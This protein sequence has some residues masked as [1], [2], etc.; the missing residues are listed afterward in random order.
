M[1]CPI[2]WDELDEVKP[3]GITIATMPERFAAL[4]DLLAARAAAAPGRLDQLLAWFALDVEAGIP[5]APWPPHYPKQLGELPRV[6]PSRAKRPKKAP[7]DGTD[8]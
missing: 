8:S 2:H 4:G 7:R 5:D 1:A 3:D 6:A